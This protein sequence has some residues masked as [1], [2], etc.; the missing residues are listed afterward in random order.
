MVTLVDSNGLATN[1]NHPCGSVSTRS[2]T[3]L[4]REVIEIATTSAP[5]TLAPSPSSNLPR[6][7]APFQKRLQLDFKPALLFRKQL[8]EPNLCDVVV[9]SLESK[10]LRPR[11]QLYGVA[12]PAP[13]ETD[14]APELRIIAE[15]FRNLTVQSSYSHPSVPRLPVRAPHLHSGGHTTLR[16]QDVRLAGHHVIHDGR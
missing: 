11:V 4:F 13:L 7:S 16:P 15:G 9:V 2:V 8:R 12:P 14:V 6:T 1:S 3:R 10:E 5:P